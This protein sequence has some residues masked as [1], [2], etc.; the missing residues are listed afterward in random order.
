MTLGRM[1]F[2]RDQLQA[3][4]VT[5]LRGIAAALNEASAETPRGPSTV[6]NLLARIAAA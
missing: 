3:S 2:R 4:G 6:R 1:T 5:S